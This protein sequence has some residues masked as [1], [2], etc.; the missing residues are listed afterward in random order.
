MEDDKWIDYDRVAFSLLSPLCQQLMKSATEDTVLKLNALIGDTPPETLQV[1][2][3]YILMPLCL[4]L[5]KKCVRLNVKIHIVDCLS[6]CIQKT[7]VVE[8]DQFMRIFLEL[9]GLI[10]DP[11]LLNIDPNIPEELKLSVLKCVAVLIVNASNKVLDDFYCEKSMPLISHGIHCCLKLAQEELF[12]DLRIAALDC[13]LHVCQVHR[14]NHPNEIDAN[15]KVGHILM[16]CFPGITLGLKKV[17]CADEKQNH[18]ITMLAI[19]A[20]S[21][22]TSQV[23]GG[24]FT[25]E[26]DEADDDDWVASKTDLLAFI[27]KNKQSCNSDSRKL[28]L[29]TLKEKRR[30]K[31]WYSCASRSIFPILDEICLLYFS[32]WNVRMEMVSAAELLLTHSRNMK[33]CVPSLVGVLLILSED[34]MAVVSDKSKGVLDAF[35]KNFDANHSHTLIEVMGDHFLKVTQKLSFS[36]PG[37]E[38]LRTSLNMMCGYLRLLG[39]HS[40]KII[41]SCVHLDAMLSALFKTVKLDYLFVSPIED[42]SLGTSGSDILKT[43]PPWKCFRNF[44]EKS[45]FGK[46]KDICFLI[47]Q[48]SDL[49][50]LSHYLLHLFYEDIENQREITLVINE[51][52]SSVPSSQGECVFPIIKRIIES[53][54]DPEMW[55]VDPKGGMGGGVVDLARG[56]TMAE[57]KGRTVEACLLVEGLGMLARIATSAQAHALSLDSWYFRVCLYPILERIGQ[58]NAMLAGAG[59][60]ALAHISEAM[61]VTIPDII[62]SNSDYVIRHV[63]LKMK[64]ASGFSSPAPLHVLVAVLEFS[65]PVIL[66]EL[67][68]AV[69]SVVNFG[70]KYANDPRSLNCLKCLLVFTKFVKMKFPK[71]IKLSKMVTVDAAEMDSPASSERARTGRMG[72][73]TRK[74]LDYKRL[75]ETANLNLAGDQC[76][77]ESEDECGDA[78]DSV[79]GEIDTDSD[80]TKEKPPKHVMLTVQVLQQILAFISSKDKEKKLM[81]LDIIAEGIQI[82]EGYDDEL[83]PL[84]HKIWSPL[85]V[86]FTSD[87]PLIMHCAFNLLLVL[88]LVAKSFITERTLRKVLPEL[89]KFLMKQSKMS[90]KKDSASVYR[91]SQ[92]YKL[93]YSLLS[94]LGDLAINLEFQEQDLCEML[95]ATTPY[96]SSLQPQPLQDACINVYKLAWALDPNIT[97]LKLA[98]LGNLLQDMKPPSQ[99]FKVYQ[100]PHQKNFSVEYSK[101]VSLLI[102]ILLNDS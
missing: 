10:C 99:E 38:D 48:Y 52:F 12:I 95:A 100:I 43:C 33:E 92:A 59:K 53:Y 83:L 74:L 26:A 23:M 31:E 15:D 96:L 41:R 21:R 78:E 85:M 89:S 39:R 94:G 90:C 24:C 28:M 98:H 5:K 102:S 72:S 62:H 68:E 75:R 36:T 49:N 45:I 51:I 35:A 69:E 8:L 27:D 81:A 88:A 63:I 58:P 29:N 9:F 47:A 67:E 37:E 84:V 76:D 91:F 32:N 13:L 66:N 77:S 80:K 19:R 70:F 86:Q 61:G 87:D 1:Y 44:K 2:R 46:F 42:W 7:K 93:Q 97:F 101:N 14:G 50:V 25:S 65:S 22:I 11:T 16:I 55:R 60:L 71:P 79:L 34:E 56:D 57:I 6:T 82:A 73:V 20:W 17:I 18:K 64:K 30:T 40:H 4:S 3:R 54:L